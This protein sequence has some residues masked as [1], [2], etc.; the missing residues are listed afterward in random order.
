MADSNNTKQEITFIEFEEET[1]KEGHPLYKGIKTNDLSNFKELLFH[2]L[3][4]HITT[5]KDININD[6]R[7]SKERWHEYYAEALRSYLSL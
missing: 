5:V 2:T 6:V 7:L 1:A 3:M 4:A